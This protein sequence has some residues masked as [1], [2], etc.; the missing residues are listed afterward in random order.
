[1]EG[2]INRCI[3][4]QLFDTAPDGSQINWLGTEYSSNEDGTVWTVK[5]NDTTKFHDSSPVTAEDVKFTFDRLLSNVEFQH[6]TPFRDLLAT[7]DAPDSSTVVF[8]CSKPAPLFNLLLGQHILSK[9]AFEEYG[10]TFWEK[11]IGSG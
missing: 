4:D 9:K 10:E 11:A 3:Y 2:E 5:M 1:M 6:S 8:N 7:V